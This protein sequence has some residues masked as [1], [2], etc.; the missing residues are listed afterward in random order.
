MASQGQQVSAIFT[1]DNK[2]L[3][4][5]AY[6]RGQREAVPYRLSAINIE[7]GKSESISARTDLRLSRWRNNHQ[8]LMVGYNPSLQ[9]STLFTYNIDTKKISQAYTATKQGRINSMMLT[10]DGSILL[11]EIGGEIYGIET[12]ELNGN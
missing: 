8:L 9:R 4:A 3:I 7:D 10:N 12:E 11:Y 1:Q 5:A 2:R 6:D